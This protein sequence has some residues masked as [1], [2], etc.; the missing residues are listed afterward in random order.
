[1]VILIRSVCFAVTQHT[2]V[3]RFLEYETLSYEIMVKLGEIK[4]GIN[5]YYTHGSYD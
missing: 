3:L 5:A 1:M 2:S 4:S